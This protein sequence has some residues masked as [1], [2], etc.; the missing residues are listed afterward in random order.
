[1][2][3]DFYGLVY[4]LNYKKEK[5]EAIVGGGTNYYKGDHFGK[6]I[7]MQYPGNTEM[8]H[9][10]YLNDAE[11]GE[12]SIYGKIK[13]KLNNRLTGYGDLQ[14]RHISY[15]MEGPDDDLRDI[16]QSHYFNFVNPK[17]GLYFSIS[18]QQDTYLSFSVAH[19]E[20]TRSDF[21]E[22]SGDAG[23]VP[24]AETLYDTEAGY[25]LK[26]GM[27]NFGL[28][29]FGMYY[30]DQLVPTG[31]LSNVGYPIMTNVKKSY[32]TGVELTLSIRPAAAIMWNLNTTL[33]RN[34]IPGFTEFY[35]EYDTADWSSAYESRYLGKVDIAY[36]PAIISSS[37]LEFKISE[38]FRIHFISKYVG[39]QYFD[40]T[41]SSQRMLDPYFVN[42]L[43]LDFEPVV[44]LIKRTELQL[45]INN[46]FDTAYESNAYGGN[47]FENGKEKSWA[48]YFPQAG[49][50][51]MVRLGLR[52]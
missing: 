24:R 29:L 49:I 14:Y 38:N 51:F 13:Y 5:I 36:S 12:F 9:K 1:M 40:N 2:K 17:A 44:R 48:Y 27:L 23:A 15:K 26:K 34:K 4:S 45:L 18:P 43:R 42:N 19:R 28:N 30:S 39:R 10:W 35:T 6:I 8:D 31:E 7:W 11:K 21:K 41:M 25:L 3:N 32:R 16:S 52:F 37:D 33:S 20:P 50:N 22:A 46:I 47:W